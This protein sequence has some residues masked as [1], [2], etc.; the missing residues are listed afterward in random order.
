M[1]S[2]RRLSDHTPITRNDKLCYML[3]FEILVVRPAHGSTEQ[4]EKALP[5]ALSFYTV[6]ID[7]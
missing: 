2:R 1:T 7:R 3:F 6:Q 4:R 5:K